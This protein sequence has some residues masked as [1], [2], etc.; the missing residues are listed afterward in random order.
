M[1]RIFSIARLAAASA[2]AAGFSIGMAG[3]A[4]ASVNPVPGGIYEIFAPYFNPAH[5]KCLDVPGGSTSD[6]VQLQVFH[7]HGFAPDGAP[8]L[9]QFRSV[10]SNLYW[11]INQSSGK[12]ITV[13]GTPLADLGVYQATCSASPS[14]EWQIIPSAIDPNGFKLANSLLGRCMATLDLSGSDHT[15]VWA[16]SCQDSPVLDGLQQTTIWELG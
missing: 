14:R 10:G 9:F 11:V 8:Q 4:Q 12:C 13:N 7:C 15:H 3:A 5:P 1:R 2:M 6:S 16:A